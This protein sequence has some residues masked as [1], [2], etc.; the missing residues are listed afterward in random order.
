M[1]W[2][3]FRFSGLQRGAT[4]YENGNLEHRWSLTT[5]G[6]DYVIY[7]HY[8]PWTLIL[9]NYGLLHYFTLYLYTSDL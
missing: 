2:L 3:G 7:Q 8:T 6:S 9:V 1:S 5:G 4:S